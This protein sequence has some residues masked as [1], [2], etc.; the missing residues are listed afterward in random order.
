MDNSKENLILHV[1]TRYSV[2]TP[3]TL[4]LLYKIFGS[5]QAVW[6]LPNQR[7]PKFLRALISEQQQLAFQKVLAAADLSRE[8]EYLLS[9]GIWLCSPADLKYPE[10]LKHIHNP[11][12]LLYCRGNISSNVAGSNSAG[13]FYLA[14]IGSRKLSDYGRECISQILSGF[15]DLPISIV[16]G[17][18]LGADACAHQQALNNSL[19]TV[20]VLGSGIDDLSIYPRSHYALAKD[21][22]GAGGGIISEYPPGT[23][24]FPAFFPTRNRIIAGM[25]NAVLVA[26]AGT[27]SGTFITAQSALEEGRDLWAVPGPITHS[28]SAGTNLLIFQ[29]AQVAL[30]SAAIIEAYAQLRGSVKK[31]NSPLLPGASRREAAKSLFLPSLGEKI[32]DL[33]CRGKL[34]IEEVFSSTGALPKEVNQA[35]TTLELSGKIIISGGFCCLPAEPKI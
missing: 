19:H 6:E 7:L 27:K 24:A 23:A 22:L 11:P 34:P 30:H 18:A 32:L 25:S 1:F 9:L 21:I 35:L 31:T 12:L 14:V 13:R 15:E 2:F 28:Q 4:R 29:G 5:Y 20:A 17:L 3:K 26:E 8:E 10:L 33:L 16:S